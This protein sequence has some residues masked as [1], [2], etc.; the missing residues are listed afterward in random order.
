MADTEWIGPTVELVSGGVVR[1]IA[2]ASTAVTLSVAAGTFLG[3]LLCLPEGRWTTPARRALTAYLQLF[4]GLPVLVTL[5]IVFF[6]SPSLGLR[7]DSFSAAALGLS[8]WGSAN[9]ME[10]VRGAVRS[11]PTAQFEAA[12][13]LGF[14]WAPAMRWVVL[15]QAIRRALPPLVNLVVDLIQ[16][17]TLASLIG[18]IDVLQRS[19]QAVEFYQLSSGEGH[20]VPIFTGVL[21]VFFLLCFPLTR[22]AARLERRADKP[23][24][25]TPDPVTA[26]GAAGERV[27]S[28]A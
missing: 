3:V 8:L 2:L 24:R 18:V 15:P 12:S 1:T 11:I 4:R 13:A 16:A 9:V 10:V 28:T 20:A 27:G 19:R 21:A 23:S 6:V 26:E 25:P 17:T 22:L 14:G 7:L 5:F